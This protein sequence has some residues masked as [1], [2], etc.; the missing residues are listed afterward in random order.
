MIELAQLFFALLA[1][2]LAT[3]GRP[4]HLHPAIGTKVKAQICRLSLYKRIIVLR[5]TLHRSPGLSAESQ[6]IK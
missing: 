4:G 2:V 6:S 1:S 5:A 3:P